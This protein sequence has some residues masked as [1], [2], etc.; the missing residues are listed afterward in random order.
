MSVL[1]NDQNFQDEYSELKVKID[2]GFSSKEVYSTEIKIINDTFKILPFRV[3]GG[4]ASAQ[5][6]GS[7][8]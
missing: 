5:E 4:E 7:P 2:D 3:C 1:R 6:V 8:S